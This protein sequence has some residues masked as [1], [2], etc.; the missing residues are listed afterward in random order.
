MEQ[1]PR[2]YRVFH[3]LGRE[4]AG[5][6][7]VHIIPKDSEV[8][9]VSFPGSFFLFFYF[10]FCLYLVKLNQTGRRRVRDLFSGRDRVFVRERSNECPV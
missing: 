3:L 2:P 7:L 8:F 10:F 1:S 6:E 5:Y 9:P 4:R